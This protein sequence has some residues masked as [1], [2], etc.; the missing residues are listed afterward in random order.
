PFRVGVRE[1][2]RNAADL[3]NGRV[4]VDGF[5]NIGKGSLD[6]FHL[7]VRERQDTDTG[8]RDD[9][10]V[11]EVAPEQHLLHE[12]RARRLVS[13]QRHFH[14]NGRAVLPSNRTVDFLETSGRE[15]GDTGVEVAHGSGDEARIEGRSPDDRGVACFGFGRSWRYLRHEEYRANER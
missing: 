8:D 5:G 10:R 7:D 12:A 14:R 1:T 15:R 6:V 9:I 11:T 13:V 2:I 3:Q 4:Q